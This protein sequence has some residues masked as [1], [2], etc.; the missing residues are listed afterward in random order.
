MFVTSI[1]ALP[2]YVIASIRSYGSILQ[3]RGRARA[4]GRQWLCVEQLAATLQKRMWRA[5][6]RQQAASARAARRGYRDSAH[7]KQQ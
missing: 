7:R 2:R 6:R 1:G 4:R 3:V 5:V